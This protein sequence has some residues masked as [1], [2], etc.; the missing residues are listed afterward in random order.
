MTKK[1]TR[2]IARIKAGLDKKVY[3]GN[4]ASK[5]D[6]GFAPEYIEA[7]WAILQQEKPDDF[8]IATGETHSVQEFLAEAFQYAGLG[9]W[10]S[11]VEI[12]KRYFRPTDVDALVGNAQKAKEKLGWEPKIK[13]KDLVK[14]M[15]DAD[16]RAQKLE[17]P[18]QGD[19]I[20]KEKFPDKWWKVD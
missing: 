3:L 20:L 7:M 14:I 5:R 10:Q 13:F 9:N 12:D 19:K 11:Y 6:W 4:L 1:I 15:I 18:G 2:A 8:V 17:P 16:F